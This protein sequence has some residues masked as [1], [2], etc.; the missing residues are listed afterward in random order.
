MRPIL[1]PAL[2]SAFGEGYNWWPTKMPARTFASDA[3]EYACLLQGHDAPPAPEA[4]APP[5]AAPPS[6]A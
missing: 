1:V 5:A 2:I 3:E 4:G 6:Q